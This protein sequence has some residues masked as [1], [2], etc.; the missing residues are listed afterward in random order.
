LVF[1]LWLGGRLVGVY[2]CGGGRLVGVC[3]SGGMGGRL[4]FVLWG[5]AGWCL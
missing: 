4:V 3:G 1:V 2:G 5:A